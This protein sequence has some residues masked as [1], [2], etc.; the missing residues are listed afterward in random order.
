MS[1]E[2]GWGLKCGGV[3]GW[4]SGVG[5]GGRQWVPTH[6][7]GTGKK[8]EKALRGERSLAV[9]QWLASQRP[10]CVPAECPQWAWPHCLRFDLSA[11]DQCCTLFPPPLLIYSFLL[12]LTPP[13]YWKWLH[14]SQ[15]RDVSE[16]ICQSIGRDL[17]SDN[18]WEA[19]VALFQNTVQCIIH[20]LIKILKQYYLSN[21]HT[22]FSN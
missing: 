13:V 8:R 1:T 15:N 10:H 14:N 4:L 2:W 7:W 19:F 22:T 21:F 17:R 20:T 18:Q 6:C 11:E 3:W 5:Q 9:L 12:L 16:L